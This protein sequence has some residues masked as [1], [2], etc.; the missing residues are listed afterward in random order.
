MT[1]LT[2][3]ITVDDYLY[4]EMYNVMSQP[5]TDYT[6]RIEI[7]LI[8]QGYIY[9]QFYPQQQIAGDLNAYGGIKFSKKMTFIIEIPEMLEVERSIYGICG[10]SLRNI[11]G[12]SLAGKPSTNLLLDKKEIV[13]AS[14]GK[15][16]LNS[17]CT[18]D[19]NNCMIYFD[20]ESKPIIDAV[21]Y[22]KPD[23]FDIYYGLKATNL[24]GFMD[25]NIAK[26]YFDKMNYY[27][28]YNQT[29][30]C[31][32]YDICKSEGDNPISLNNKLIN[33]Y[34]SDI[35]DANN[36]IY[37]NIN[38]ISALVKC[39]E[40]KITDLDKCTNCI[41][42]N[43]NCEIPYCSDY[44]FIIKDDKCIMVHEAP[45]IDKKIYS[46]DLECLQILHGKGYNPSPSAKSN[47]YLYWIIF[48]IIFFIV[49][50]SLIIY[51]KYNRN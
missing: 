21:L 6:V 46:S 49:I 29:G 27:N 22:A 13:I 37:N 30:S 3:N 45:S 12:P 25:C 23:E 36:C 24:N 32:N 38:D 28:N 33:K 26:I 48:L 43:E 47:S 18:Y 42:N 7:A 15:P 41:M 50:I 35:N 10:L 5:P 40:P 39:I 51:R 34:Y 8:Q 44:G 31:K 2:I 17:N 16:C 9:D 1:K 20:S 11:D 19:S 14:C 4:Q